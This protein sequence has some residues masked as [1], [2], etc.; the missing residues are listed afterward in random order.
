MKT[1]NTSPMVAGGQPFFVRFL[2]LFLRPLWTPEAD[3]KRFLKWQ[4]IGLVLILCLWRQGIDP[5]G[6]GGNVVLANFGLWSVA[7]VVRFRQRLK[8]RGELKRVI[9]AVAVFGGLL[10]GE[11]CW[12][13]Y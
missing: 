5:L 2:R 11:Q 6:M 9:F 1:N 12:A 10:L 7:Y 8:D 3:E 13:L 4:M